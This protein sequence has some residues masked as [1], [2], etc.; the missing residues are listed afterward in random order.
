MLH[1]LG[2]GVY[3]LGF[4]RRSCPGSC[5]STHLVATEAS[6]L[7]FGALAGR[8]DWLERDP[9]AER[10]EGAEL[11][12]RLRAP[13]PSELLVFTRWVLVMNTFERA[14]YADPDGDL[15]A[16]WW[17]LVQR[18]Q[19]VTPPDD[20][21]APDW[22]AKIH[23]AVSP[24]YYHT[25]LYGAI[26]ALQLDA[27]LESELGGIVDRP[28]A[29]ALLRERL[30][31]PGESIRWDRLVEQASGAPLSV[32]F[33][34]RAVA[35][36]G[37]MT[38]VAPYVQEPTA[39]EE[40]RKTSYLELFF[41]LV[42]VFAFTQ[43]TALIL[44]DTSPQG[45][46][47]AAL[48]LAMVWW[49]WS[50]YAWMT[51]A[52]D[53]ENAVTRLIM[54][55]AMAAG[56]FM[57]L[58]VPDAFQDEAA[59][60][61]VAYFVVRVLNPTLYTWGVRDDPV[62]LR[63]MVRLAP[64]FLVAAFVALVGGFV[65]ADY[66]AWVWLAS[67][68]I[69]VVGTLTVARVEWRVSPSHF[70]E[71]FALIVIIALGESIVAIGIGTSGLRARHDL[72][73]LGDRRVRRCR[74]AVVG[75]LRLHRRRR[76]AGAPSRLA[77]GARADGTR[78]LHVLP[79]PGGARDHPLRGRGEEDARASARPALGGGALGARARRSRSSSSGFAL[80]RFRVVRRVAWER[81]AAAVLALVVA[82]VLDG[83]DAIVTLGVVIV[84][85]VLSV[86]LET[87]RLRELRAEIRAG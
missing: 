22:A 67:L 16:L 38:D 24:V 15:D 75:V 61:A 30:Y 45:F 40:E 43:V 12:G 68:V 44:E 80:M 78:R 46:A 69:D 31:A 70:A 58:A 27:A 8:R 55:A 35:H 85:L 14:L 65:D 49:A 66:R 62:H 17:E 5:A 83:A 34:E 37:A 86:A 64:W 53:V 63:A 84:I 73:P 36:A 29:G 76:R 20:R 25:Y 33:L 6:A 39:E 71:R 11:E 50:A 10:G 72:R 13:A 77:A 81:L 82:V 48:V 59:W 23:I 26:V 87:A 79:L 19:G 47:R 57:A 32:E 3:D 52:I 9:R 60:F 4:R 51:N 18:Y 1:E 7:L 56:F 41:D 21:R 42:F 74:R 2:H 28:E 54:F